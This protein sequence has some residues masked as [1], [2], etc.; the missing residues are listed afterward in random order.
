MYVTTILSINMMKL[1][2]EI[3]EKLKQITTVIVSHNKCIVLPEFTF[4]EN[5]EL[6]RLLV[7]VYAF[8]YVQ[9]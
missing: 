8:R 6:K 3:N 1:T 5:V 2:I 9:L 4:D 7:H